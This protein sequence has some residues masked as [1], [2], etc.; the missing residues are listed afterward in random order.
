MISFNEFRNLDEKF[1]DDLFG[2]YAHA[3][4]T[5]GENHPKVDRIK[6]KVISRYGE[7]AFRHMHGA[8]TEYTYGNEQSAAKHY[9]EYER[10]AVDEGMSAL[11][12]YHTDSVLPSEKALKD[13]ELLLDKIRR[14]IK[15]KRLGLKEGFR[16]ADD[17]EHSMAQR[18]LEGMD[19]SEHLAIKNIGVHDN[20]GH[21]HIHYAA[22]GR[23]GGGRYVVLD[24]H[25][26]EMKLSKGTK[27]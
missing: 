26:K 25:G 13:R 10:H 4:R 3:L 5:H 17:H 9:N 19:D 20:K 1:H 22:K 7:K 11:R 2:E 21:I 16:R 18:Y 27:K 14:L 15:K 8:A 12:R 23:V 24:K 6:S